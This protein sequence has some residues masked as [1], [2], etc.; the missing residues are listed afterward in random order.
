M[1][2]RFGQLFSEKLQKVPD[3]AE[4]HEK[5][6][7]RSK[8]AT[9]SSKPPCFGVWVNFSVKKEKRCLVPRKNIGNRQF[10]QKLELFR[11]NHH[12]SAF[13]S[14]FQQRVAESASFSEKA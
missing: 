8:V 5:S 9:F 13:G 4:K 2:R 14:T 7:I 10:G 12:V 3:F 11:A 6:S 1:F